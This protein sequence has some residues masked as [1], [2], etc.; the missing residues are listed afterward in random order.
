MQDISAS[1]EYIQTSLAGAMC[2]GLERGKFLRNARSTCLNLLLT[3]SS[4]CRAACSYCGLNRYREIDSSQTFIRVKWPTYALEEVIH[5]L[6]V[7]KHPFKRMCLS[8]IT[9]AK[10]VE[11]SCAIIA[12]FN[13]EIKD[14]PISALISPSVMEGK[15]DLLRLKEAGVE[16]IGIAIDAATPSLFEKFRGREVGGPHKWEK[17]WQTIE[18]AVEIFGP[19]KV[20]AHFIVGLGESEQEMVNIISQA[21]E[22]KVLTHL[23]SFYPE[24]GSP[25]ENYPQPSMGQYRRIQL[26]RYLINEVCINPAIIE[27]NKNG[28]VI[29]F[30]IDL[31]EFLPSGLAFMTSGCPGADGKVACNRP[32]ANERVNQPLRNYPFV[33]DEDDMS[34]VR[35]QLWEG[36]EQ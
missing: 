17:Y 22:R 11:D 19:Y 21:Y 27:F 31:E 28:Q 32:F 14:I 24:A 7:H 6:Q 30:G 12:K 35:S 23:F 34:M 8:M 13:R 33:P 10:A 3:Y 9:H 25:M 15:K 5:Q 20:G 36:L 2:L 26:A 1:P 18:E 29:D 16:R 4:G